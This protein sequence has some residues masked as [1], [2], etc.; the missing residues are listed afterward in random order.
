MITLKKPSDKGDYETLVLDGIKY[1][2][3]LVIWERN[4]KLH[5]TSKGFLG[6]RYLELDKANI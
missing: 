3:D 4:E 6:V 2:I 5:I 1:Y